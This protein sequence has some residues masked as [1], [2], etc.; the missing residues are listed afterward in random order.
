MDF[1][2]SAVALA[3]A[4]SA[5]VPGLTFEAIDLTTGGRRRPGPSGDRRDANVFVRGVFHILKGG[6]RDAMARNLRPIVGGS[7][8]LLLAETNFPGTLLGY[9]RHLGAS[10]QYIPPAL[11]RAIVDL[12]A[13]GHFGLEQRRSTFGDRDWTVVAEGD[14]EIEAIPL[15]G[16]QDAEHIPGYFA[17]LAPR[18]AVAGERAAR[19][20]RVGRRRDIG[21]S[22]ADHG[23]PERILPGELLRGGRGAGRAVRRHR[24]G[25]GRGRGAARAC[26]RSTHVTPVA[27]LLTHGHLDHTAAAAEICRAHGIPAYIHPGDEY[28]LDDPLAALSPELRAALPACRCKAAARRPCCPR[29]DLGEPGLA[30]LPLTALHVPG[31]TPGSVVIPARGRRRPARDVLFT[32]DTLFAGSIGRTDLSGRVAG[33]GARVD[34]VGDSDARPDE[35]VVAPGHGPTTTVGAERAGNPFLTGR[36]RTGRARAAAQPSRTDRSARIRRAEGRSRVLPARVAGL[37]GG[38]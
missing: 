34:R 21:W 31:H 23:I 6:E 32:G 37:R 10:A 20:R 24:P 17:V 7:G 9:L 30:G 36:A 3:R 14:T 28:M 18:A 38:P 29:A 15:H 8:R 35:T 4:E 1:A 27:V 26:W 5:G 25:R 16:Q 12:P 2:E 13:P 33:P 19:R 11:E 22:R